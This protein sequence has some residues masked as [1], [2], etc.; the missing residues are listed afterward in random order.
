MSFTK[1]DYLELFIEHF[2]EFI[3]DIAD[4]YI[5]DDKVQILKHGIIFN[6]KN[7]QKK[8]IDAWKNYVCNN[9]RKQI[10][11]NN[12]NFFIESREWENIINHSKRD[13]II[14]KLSQ[15]RQSISELSIENKTK[16]LKYVENLI[17]LNDLYNSST[18]I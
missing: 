7:N 18:S 11:E 10:S 8:V 3:E 12:F 5:N 2:I 9:F 14:A 16:A 1:D 4:L 17:K 15:L 13:L 6:A